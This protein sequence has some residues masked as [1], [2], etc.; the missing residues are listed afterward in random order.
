MTGDKLCKICGDRP[1]AKGRTICETC[2]KQRQRENYNGEP[3]IQANEKPEKRVSPV[4]TSQDS[5][6]QPTSSKAKVPS[7]DEPHDA[8][9]ARRL[10]ET[11]S[12]YAI[13]IKVGYPPESAPEVEV[14][15]KYTE[16]DLD[17]AIKFV[18]AS[19]LK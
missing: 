10:V 4:Q 16:E 7:S 14:P 9:L 17:A 19:M 15:S 11:G 8:W 2:K 18:K 1:P 3:Q 5:G 6:Q 13:K 12:S